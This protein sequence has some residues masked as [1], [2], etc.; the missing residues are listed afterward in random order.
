MVKEFH[1]AMD[2]YNKGLAVDPENAACRDG[3]RKVEMQIRFGRANMTEEEKKQQA[4]NAMSDP[5][6]QAI[7]T[8]PLMQQ[9]LKDL[10]ENPSSAQQA[11]QDAGVFS[12]I[13]KLIAAGIIERG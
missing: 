2:S 1:K 6:I 11:M 5:E 3:L 4:A 13:E 9:L 12:K 8:D 10:S 7:L